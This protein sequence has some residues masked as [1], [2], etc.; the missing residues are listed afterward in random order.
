MGLTGAGKSSAIRTLTGKDVFVEH[1][2][3]AGI[4][5]FPGLCLAAI[6]TVLL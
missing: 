6:L 3:S 4:I 5:P 2:I 1:G